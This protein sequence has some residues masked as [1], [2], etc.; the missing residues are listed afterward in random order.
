MKKGET[1]SSTAEEGIV[2]EGIKEIVEIFHIERISTEILFL[3]LFKEDKRICLK[4]IY[5]Q[6][7]L[8]TGFCCML[9]PWCAGSRQDAPTQKEKTQ[10]LTDV[11]HLIRY[12]NR[13]KVQF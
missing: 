1:H 7:I 5:R 6:G 2:T 10:N 4:R 9:F 8:H 11:T 13:A 12:K 3:I